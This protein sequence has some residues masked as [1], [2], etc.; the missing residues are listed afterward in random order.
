MRADE[1]KSAFRDDRI[2]T[3]LSAHGWFKTYNF[4]SREAA[5]ERWHAAIRAGAD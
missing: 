1:V 4:G 3:E 5:S 2:V